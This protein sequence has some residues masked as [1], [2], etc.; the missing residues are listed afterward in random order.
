MTAVDEARDRYR[1]TLRRATSALDRGRA[2]LVL[3]AATDLA[4][5]LSRIAATSTLPTVVL[6]QAAELGRLAADRCESVDGDAGECLLRAGHE[7]W[8]KGLAA[9]WSGGDR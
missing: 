1:E 2:P 6:S 8:H 5:L 4:E 7:G 3:V 9:T